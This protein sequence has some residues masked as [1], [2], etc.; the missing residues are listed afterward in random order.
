MRGL[1]LGVSVG[2]FAASA[3]GAAPTSPTGWWRTQMHGATVEIRDCGD[4]SPCAFLAR[5]DSATA[6]GNTRDVRN[7]DA[8]LRDRPLIGVPIL[9]GLRPSAAGWTGGGAYNPETG[10][11]FRSSLRVLPND[12]LQ[13]TGCLG[14]LCRSE[15]WVRAHP[16]RTIEGI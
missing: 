4:R 7:P 16:V 13:V 12:R 5:V 3:A 10:Q 9:W 6:K 15:I 1:V 8:R 14:P 2:C 11:T